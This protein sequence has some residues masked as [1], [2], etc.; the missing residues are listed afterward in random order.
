MYVF[1]ILKD[2]NL[3]RARILIHLKSSNVQTL[4]IVHDMY[5]HILGKLHV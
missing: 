3:T 1:P 4:A 5:Y 2:F